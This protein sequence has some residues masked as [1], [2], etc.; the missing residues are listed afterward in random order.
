MRDRALN[1]K[2]LAV[3]YLAAKIFARTLGTS[4][5]IAAFVS[6]AVVAGCLKDRLE[7]LRFEKS[8]KTKK[9]K[10]K[11]SSL[12]QRSDGSWRKLD[13]RSKMGKKIEVKYEFAEKGS[14]DERLGKKV[15]QEV[16]NVETVKKREPDLAEAM[17]ELLSNVKKV[18]IGGRSYGNYETGMWVIKTTDGVYYSSRLV[19][20]SS[21]AGISGEEVLKSFN[22]FV[23]QIMKQAGNNVEIDELTFLHTHPGSGVPLSLGDRDAIHAIAHSL[24]WKAS[25]GEDNTLFRIYALPVEDG[26]QIVFKYAVEP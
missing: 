24:G 18:E 9:L 21:L 22:D 26:G 23:D 8:K 15:S 7:R 16:T 11:V 6:N 14:F 12:D 25:D 2:S 3:F 17:K 19:S 10:L 5:L 1:R 13:W 20:S 4:L